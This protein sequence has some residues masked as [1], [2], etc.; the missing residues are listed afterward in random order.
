MTHPDAAF[1]P[2]SRRRTVLITLA[3][4]AA[5]AVAFALHL[6]GVVAPG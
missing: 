3:V 1:P 6:T 2:P 4:I 5:A